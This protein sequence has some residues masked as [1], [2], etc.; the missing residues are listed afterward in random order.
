MRHLSCLLFALA[1]IGAAP[2]AAWGAPADEKGKATPKKD[3]VKEAL[4]LPPGTVLRSDQQAKYK[5]VKEFYE[6]KLREA[7]EKH[8]KASESEKHKAYVDLKKLRDE[9]DEA[10]AQILKMP[11][12]TTSKTTA[13]S[14][15]TSPSRQTH[16]STRPTAAHALRPA[17]PRATTAPRARSI[18]AVRPYQY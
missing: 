4:A 5:E 18:Q 3:P 7:I 8:D 14:S 6:P 15:T 17:T 2:G 9:I 16:R 12:S 1:A 13:S 10:I 11:G